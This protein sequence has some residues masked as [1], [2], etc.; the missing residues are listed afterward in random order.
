MDTLKLNAVKSIADSI[1]IEKFIVLQFVNA[2][3]SSYNPYFASTGSVTSV[4]KRI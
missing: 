4:L 1:N 2:A 3:I